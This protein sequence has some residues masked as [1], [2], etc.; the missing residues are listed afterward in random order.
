MNRRRFLAT[1]TGAALAIRWAS[2]EAALPGAT[3]TA[4]TTESVARPDASIGNRTDQHRFGVNYTPSHNWW[5]CWND[6]DTDPIKK[7]LDQ[8]AS[9]GLDHLRI[10]P[11]WPFFQPN[12]TYVSSAHLDRLNQLLT[13]MGERNMDAVVTIFTGQLSG[14]YFL[15]PFAKSK[16]H[17]YTDPQMWSAQELMI[18]ETAKVLRAHENIIGFDFGNEM[19]SCWQDTQTVGDAWMKKMFALMNAEL[20]KGLHVNGAGP[21]PWFDP[22]TFSPE[23]MASYPLP[24]MHAYP[25]WSGA[26]RYGG[27][28][29]PPSTKLLTAFAALIRSYARNPQKPVWAAEYN[30]CIESM[31][32]KQQA[33]WLE[34]ATLGAIESGVCWFSFWDSYDTNRKFKFASLE[35]S[36]GL[37]TNDRRLKEQGRVYKELAAAYRGKP[38]RIPK[39]SLPE[40][41]A[42]LTFATTWNWLNNYIGW[43]PKSPV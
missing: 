22:N 4:E 16:D 14:Q 28:M 43:V 35:Y 24:V 26:L 5:F 13:L 42:E 11:I 27:P 21:D 41:P 37:F 15:P 2:A 23:A 30:T 39:A 38:V 7:D 12:A 17:F 8:L 6:W 34:T 3:S 25:H 31:P 32:E 9:L 1:G 29:D 10:F 18:K 20:P 36:L 33:Q 19:Q 40:P